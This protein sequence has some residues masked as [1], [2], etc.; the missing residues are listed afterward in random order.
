[1]LFSFLYINK[2]KMDVK[3]LYIFLYILLGLIL[4]I[5]E[6]HFIWENYYSLQFFLS[7]GVAYTIYITDYDFFKKLLIFIL[8]VQ[9]FLQ[10]YEKFSSSYIFNYVRIIGDKKITISPNLS[11]SFR[12]KGLFKGSLSASAFSMNISF[13]FSNNIYILFLSFI[14]AV[15]ATGRLG[16][17]ITFLIILIY[18]IFNSKISIILLFR[19]LSVIVVSILIFAL[20]LDSY[21]IVRLFNTFNL[22]SASN[23]LRIFYWQRGIA[24]YINYDLKNY[25]FGENAYFFNKYNAGAENDWIHLLL[26]T[27]FL[28]FLYYIIPI[29]LIFIKS[30]IRN[31]ILISLLIFVIFIYRHLSGLSRGILHWLFIF[32]YLFNNKSVK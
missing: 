13:L 4:L 15:L 5:V 11:K 9:L 27:G 1:M 16:M 28:G 6:R 19:I 22:E 25:I 14:S 8:I 20:F 29:M 2:K 32:E 7:I 23:E 10:F 31:K 17:L 30:K 12:A 3:Y 18:L 24:E 21:A 26:E